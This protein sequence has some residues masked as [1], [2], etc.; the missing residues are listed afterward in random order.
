MQIT[1]MRKHF[2]K[3]L[4]KNL[5][6]YHDLHV[7]SD[8]LS[9]ANLYEN[10]RNMCFKRQELDPEKFISAPRLAQQAALKKTSKIRIIN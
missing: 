5:G 2:V 7:K 4:K 10:F 8:T 6:E 9:L 1:C 3:T